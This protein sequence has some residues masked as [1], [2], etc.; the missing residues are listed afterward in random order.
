MK[1]KQTEQVS[2]IIAFCMVTFGLLGLYVSMLPSGLTWANYGADG[3]DFLT[4]ILTAGVPHPSGYPTYTLLGHIFQ[5]LP[6]ATPP[7]KASLFSAICSALAAGLLTLWSAHQFESSPHKWIG[8]VITGFAWGTA[9]LV[10]GQAV[11]IEVHALQALLVVCYLW[12]FTFIIENQGTKRKLLLSLIGG[13]AIGN[14]LAILFLL[15]VLLLLFIKAIRRGVARKAI[16]AQLFCFLLGCT[17]YAVLPVYARNDSPVNWGNPQN[18]Q[19]FVWLISGKIY[20]G[21]IFGVDLPLLLQRFRAYA[22]LWIDQFSAA[23]VAIGLLGTLEFSPKKEKLINRSLIYIFL[24]YSLFAL[25]YNQN[26]SLLYLIPAL[27]VFSIWI[28]QGSIVVLS[29]KWKSFPL[30]K[31]AIFLFVLIL[32]LRVPLYFSQVDPRPHQQGPA[33]L[34]SK[35]QAAPPN[36]LI[37]TDSDPDTFA[38]WYAH[39]GANQRPDTH[40]IVPSLLPFDWYRATMRTVYPDLSIPNPGEE[41]N[42]DWRQKIAS[43]NVTLP[44][45]TSKVNEKDFTEIYFICDQ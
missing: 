38:L 30:G 45:C 6:F 35:L 18:W 39:F 24:I 20:Q 27:M 43:E 7:L 44:L 23:G 32:F 31:I 1:K 33:Q 21:H 9:P 42:L 11:I 13:L 15:P 2:L 5:W 41:Q 36:A 12:W 29:W 3:G 17:I 19:G 37:L 10:W 16:A 14:H 28:G 34:I 26:D 40:V 8:A 25:T 4:A 22:T